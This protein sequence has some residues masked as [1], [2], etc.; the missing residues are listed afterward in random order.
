L[1][2]LKRFSSFAFVVLCLTLTASA[3]AG[4]SANVRMNSVGFLPSADKRASIYNAGAGNFNIRRSGDNSIAFTAALSASAL[5]ADTNQQLRQADFSAL[6]ENGSFY[7]ECSV[8]QGP[9]FRIGPDVYNDSFW[10]MVMGLHGH[11]CGMAVSYTWKGQSF[12][13]GACHL[14]DGDLNFVGGGAKD[15]TQGWHDAGDYGKYTVNLAFT[16]GHLLQ[17]WEWHSPVLSQWQFPLPD[18][19]GPI[20]DYLQELQWG[21]DWLLKMQRNDGAAYHKLTLQNFEGTVMPEADNGT[22]YFAP[23]S[24]AATADLVAVLSMAARI[25]Q[26][27]DPA[28]AA[29]CQAAADLGWAWL[30][31]NPGEVLADLSGFGTGNYQEAG[32]DSDHRA[33]AEAEYWQTTGN[34]AALAAFE[35]RMAGDADLVSR[36]W[37][38]GEFNGPGAYGKRGPKNFGIFSY[39]LSSRP[40]RNAARVNELRTDLL[41]EADAMVAVRNAHGYGR[42]LGGVYHWGSNGTVARQAMLLDAANQISP[43]TAYV[44]T[45]LDA[46]GH[47]YGRNHYARSFVTGDGSNPPLYPHARQ[48]MADGIADPV[49]GH[50]VGGPGGQG[51]TATE[52]QDDEGDWFTNE[53]AI[54]WDAA[55]IAALARFVTVPP[56]A[57]PTPTPSP[58]PCFS[59]T[60]LRRVNVGGPQV[61][62]GGS[63]WSADQAYSAGSWGYSGGAVSTN[64]NSIAGTTDDVLYNTG[65]Y[66]LTQYQFTVPNGAYRVQLHFAETYFSW[67]GARIMSVTLEGLSAVSS[68]D[69]YATVGGSTALVLTRDTQVNDGVLSLGFSATADTPEIRAIA[70]FPAVACPATPTSTHTPNWSPTRTPTRSP[71]HT[72]S[73]TRTPSPSITP[74]P[75][76]SPTPCGAVVVARINSG[77]GAYTDGL[78]QLWSADQSFMGGTAATVADPIALTTDDPLYQSERYGSPL[79]YAI[80]VPAA[81]SYQVRFLW[82]ETFHTAPGERVFSVTLEGAVSVSNLDIFAAAGGGDRAYQLTRTVTVNDGTL[83]IAATAS[84][85]QAKFGAIEVIH[86]AP[87]CASPTP[88]F[89]PAPPSFTATRTATRSATPSSSPTASPTRSS[90]PTASSSASPTRSSTPM[91]TPTASPTRSGTPTSTPTASPTRSGT[92]AASLTASPTLTAALTASPTLTATP[93]PSTPSSTPSVSPTYTDVPPD[94]TITLTSTPT[95]S[96]TATATPTDPTSSTATPSGTLTV[97]PT[98][99]MTPTASPTLTPTTTPS[100]TPTVSPTF[101]DVPPDSTITLTSTATASPMPS[102]TSTPSGTPTVSSTPAATPGASAS[103]TVTPSSTLTAGSSPTS[104]PLPATATP[105]PASSPTVT[106]LLSTGASTPASTGPLAIEEAHWHPHPV[107]GPVAQLRFKLSGPAERLRIRVYLPS[108]ALAL[109]SETV[110]PLHRGWNS[111]SMDLGGLPAGLCYVVLDAEQGKRQSLPRAPLRLY[112]VK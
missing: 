62:T 31:A 100:P 112:L 106:P 84:A 97:S 103:S 46:I 40:G 75:T 59:A 42:P 69:I 78:G 45:A 13:H 4:T 15:G 98:F 2:A 55:L 5:N 95:P 89:T 28:Y 8:G 51:Q 18:A 48:S 38:W 25:Y 83:N 9:V 92:P 90:T 73:P 81:G 20:P 50:L 12:G 17:A 3:F 77:G 35:A 101:T 23:H 110:A 79:A 29:Q 56:P 93:L 53:I 58:T 27:Y 65:R 49:P 94:S 108:M 39:L 64:T 60:A 111:L 19:G 72:V 34:A 26:P 99:T 88:S 87:D 21:V 6:T 36:Y 74:T 7:L 52:W 68:L 54:N 44:N 96:M 86:L 37:D 66:G 102:S 76:L 107:R 61:N 33:W 80:P 1:L 16:A 41:A 11:R 67:N 32:T 91:A 43:N 57:T 24:S 63:T 47:L 30:Q 70:V 105:T 82:A 85:D 109:R 22:R 10:L 71:S 104:T 14:N